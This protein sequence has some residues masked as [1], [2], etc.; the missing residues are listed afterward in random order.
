MMVTRFNQ[1]VKEFEI[2]RDSKKLLGH[3]NT[4]FAIGVHV[5]LG[6]KYLV[7][8]SNRDSR[9]KLSSNADEAD[10]IMRCFDKYEASYP[11]YR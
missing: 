3:I 5:R 8:A 2:W 11:L 1:V 4:N 9:T 7:G 6:D 10:H